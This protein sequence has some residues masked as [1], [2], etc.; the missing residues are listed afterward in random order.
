MFPIC[1]V[2]ISDGDLGLLE[3]LVEIHRKNSEK[4]GKLSEKIDTN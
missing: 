1:G 2:P 4:S 3:N